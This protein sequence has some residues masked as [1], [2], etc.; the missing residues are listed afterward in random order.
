MRRYTPI[1]DIYLCVLHR[2]SGIQKN[3]E[4]QPLETG[5]GLLN[6]TPIFN[7]WQEWLASEDNLNPEPSI[8][9]GQFPVPVQGELQTRRNPLKILLFVAYIPGLE[10]QQ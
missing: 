2:A 9:P 5:Y 4:D 7:F 8:H 3:Q 6:D 1:Y 10:I